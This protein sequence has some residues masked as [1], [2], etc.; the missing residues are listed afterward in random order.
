[1]DLLFKCVNWYFS[2]S[3]S[4]E[5]KERGAKD[6]KEDEK[7]EK[8]RIADK[9]WSD[10]GMKRD[11]DGEVNV[12]LDARVVKWWVTSCRRGEKSSFFLFLSLFLYFFSPFFLRE[13]VSEWENIRHE[14]RKGKKTGKSE[15]VK[16]R[17]W[18]KKQDEKITSFSLFLFEISSLALDF[19]LDE[20]FFQRIQSS[21]YFFPFF[22]FSKR[23]KNK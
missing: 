1:M 6:W 5:E 2:S 16:G 12:W 23:E 4:E 9:E 11:A 3:F 22:S 18:E 10:A 20:R 13:K 15:R 7:Q 17:E 21:C 8:M 19:V 14:P